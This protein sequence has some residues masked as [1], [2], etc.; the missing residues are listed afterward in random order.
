[1]KAI[2]IAIGNSLRRDD[3]AAQR[4]LELLG[5]IENVITRSCMQLTPEMAEEIAPAGTIVFIDADVNPGPPSLESLPH[6]PPPRTPL[7]HSVNP[8]ELV[9]LA[10]ELYFFRGSACVCHVPGVDFSE[11]EGLSP[12][13]ESNARAAAELLRRLCL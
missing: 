3:G 2:F 6:L 5:P 4:V 1:M 7:S 11:G 8:A 13:A 9:A 10:R 12:E